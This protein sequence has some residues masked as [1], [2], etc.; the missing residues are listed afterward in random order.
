[1]IDRIELGGIGRQVEVAASV[2]SIA[3]PRARRR[4]C[5]KRVFHDVDVGA[6]QGRR[7]D[8][9]DR[10]LEHFPVKLQHSH[11]GGGKRRILLE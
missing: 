10:G 5:E 1:M 7:Q 8:L 9:F 3:S 2:R 6:R 4:P 11:R